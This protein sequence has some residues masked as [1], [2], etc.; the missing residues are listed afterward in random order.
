VGRYPYRTEAESMQLDRY[1][2]DAVT[3]WETASGGQAIRCPAG[4][5]CRAT[6]RYDGSGG[7][8]DIVVQYFDENDG[9]S[10]FTLLVSD[11]VAD[12]WVADSEFPSNTPN[13][14]TS[15]RRVVHGVV[16]AAGDVIRID[17]APDRDEGAVL[18]YIEIVPARY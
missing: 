3:P 16:L 15:T 2:V 6:K 4:G 9:A 5:S 14:H 17:A 10:A 12:R 18:D 7:A 11:R 8:Y 13:G 1:A